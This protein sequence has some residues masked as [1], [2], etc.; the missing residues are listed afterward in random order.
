MESVTDVRTTKP[1]IKTVGFGYTPETTPAHFMV[2]ISTTVT[3][4]E[5]YPLSEG[6]RVIPRVAVTLP[7]WEL[8][9]PHAKAEFNRRLLSVKL[10][11]GTWK[12]GDNYLDRML[13]RELVVLLWAIEDAEMGQIPVAVANWCGLA[14]EERWWLFMTICAAT[15]HITEGKGV[16]WRKAIRYALT[17]NPTSGAGYFGH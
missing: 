3:A 1:R 5:I 16:G 14:P 7:Q 12:T 13:G 15:G 17:E 11:A 6:P 2:T 10:K 8:A 9:A 4:M